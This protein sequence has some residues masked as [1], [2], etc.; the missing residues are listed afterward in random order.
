MDWNQLTGA[1]TVPGSIAGFLNNS[2]ITSGAGGIADILLQEAVNWI[3]GSLKHWRM[4]PPPFTGAFTIGD[5]FIQ[6]P[7][8]MLEPDSLYITGTNYQK[9]SQKTMQQVLASWS[10]DG[11]GN[12]IPQQPI[13]WYFDQAAFRFDSPADKAYTYALVYYQNIPNLTPFAPNNF[14]TTFYPRLV[15][16]ATMMYATEWAKDSGVGQFDRTYWAQ[17]AEAELLSAQTESDRAR[18]GTEFAGI[19]IGGG[20]E[21]FPAY[22]SS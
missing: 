17:V 12:R 13:I 16:A 7:E 18:R 9:L 4:M 19:V 3:S 20:A 10:F 21:G 15:R 14:L 5:D 6:I 8:D 22:G 1:K 2:T 11:N